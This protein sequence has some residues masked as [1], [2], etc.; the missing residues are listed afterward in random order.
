MGGE[1]MPQRVQI[2]PPV[3]PGPRRGCVKDAVELT[4]RDRSDRL[5]TAGKQPAF[6]TAGPPP[7]AQK[8]QHLRGQHRVA[9]LAPFAILNADGHPSA[10]DAAHHEMRRITCP[11]PGPVGH[12]QSRLVPQLRSGVQNA[13]HILGAHDK[14]QRLRLADRLEILEKLGPAQRVSVEKRQSRDCYVDL[15]CGGSSRSQLDL[16]PAQI[17]SRS[18]LGETTAEHAELHDLPQIVAHR[19]GS[20]PASC[21]VLDKTLTQ[22][23][24]SAGMVWHGAHSCL[25][26]LEYWQLQFSQMMRSMRH[27]DLGITWIDFFLL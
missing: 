21:H 3:Q 13:R 6:G 10:V 20:K 12:P 16:I 27:P 25:M 11:Q 8:L 5:S 1:G 14:G 24:D 4:G 18:S 26:N 19:V 17:F 22:G 2:D 15:P 7:G 9:I 23:T